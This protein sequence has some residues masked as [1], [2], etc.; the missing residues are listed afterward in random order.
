MPFDLAITN[1]QLAGKPVDILIAG[2]RIDRIEPHDPARVLDP[3]TRVV[4]GRGTAVLPGLMNAHTHTAM[5]MLRS[6]ADDLPLMQWLQQEIWPFEAKLTEDD[7]YWGARLGCLE[8]IRTGTTFFSDM[9]WH[10]HGTARA[11][12]DAGMRAVV[13]SVFL[14]LGDAERATVQREAALRE[15]EEFRSY[16]DRVQHALGPHAIYSVSEASLRWLAE[17]A[18]ERN[19]RIHIHL[20]ETIGEV[21]GCLRDHG[22]RPVPYLDRLGILSERCFAAHS[23]HLDDEEIAILAERG[24][25][26]LHCPVSNMK[27]SSGGPMRFVAMKGAGIEPLIG[28]DGAASNNNLD[29]FEELKFAALLAKHE[30]G[31]PTVLPATEAIAMA[32]SYAAAA[33]RIDAGEVA[34]GRLADL[35]LVDL[36][37][38]FVFPGHNL[39]ADLV[40]SAAGRAVRTTICDG[41]VLMED[42]VIPDEAE[43]REEVAARLKRLAG[44]A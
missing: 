29:L 36:D 42:R 21:E 18:A 3:A 38:P 26:P 9:Y 8:M 5:A 6:Y 2:N 32:T 22:V 7:V 14:D 24:V 30:A 23:V 16:P 33:F 39:A 28:T 40:Y 10:L 31:D 44:T 41:K 19:M 34:P 35:I 4:D 20:S 15:I 27:L 37:D 13:T 25:H 43:I 12:V 17:V 11:A 1:T